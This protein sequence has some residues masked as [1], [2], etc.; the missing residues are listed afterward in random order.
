MGSRVHGL[1]SCG[2][3]AVEHRLSSCDA[4]VYLLHGLWDLPRSEIEPVFPV[5]ADRFFTTEP[6]GKPLAILKRMLC[7][8]G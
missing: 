3:Q 7:I 8:P 1:S 6:P 4:R 2:S 5:L